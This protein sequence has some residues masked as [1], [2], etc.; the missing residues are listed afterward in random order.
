MLELWIFLALLGIGFTVGH[1]LEKRHFRNIEMREAE[2]LKQV[3]T[4]SREP[5]GELGRITRVELVRGN[6]CISID[7]FKRIAASLRQLFGGTVR[8]YETLLD[9]ARREAI[10]R[11]KES[12]PGAT[13]IIN[14]RVDTSSVFQGQGRQTGSVEVL[15]TGTAI[16]ASAPNT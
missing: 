5:V 6:C 8:S 3:V 15:A 10:L 16:Y 4:S 13:Q 1:T 9:R 14:L 7:Y 12:C 11:L 2:Q